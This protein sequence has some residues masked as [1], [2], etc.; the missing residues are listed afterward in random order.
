MKCNN[1]DCNFEQDGNCIEGIDGSSCSNLYD[2][3]DIELVS[4]DED[5][6]VIVQSKTA[7]DSSKTK[8]CGQLPLSIDETQVRLKAREGKIIAFVGSIGVGKT[9]LISSMYD[10]FHKH[11]DLPMKFGCSDT[12]F[13][14]ESLCHHAR[15]TSRA[16]Q[17]HTPRTSVSE[18]VAFYHLAVKSLIGKRIDLFLADRAGESYTEIP[19]NLEFASS[20]VE[21]Q[22][23]DL[24]L[25][26]VDASCLGNLR[27][28]HVTRRATI[29]LIKSF[30]ESDILLPSK[31]CCL[32]LTKYDLVLGEDA[33]KIAESESEKI[34]SE[35]KRITTIDL[36]VMSISAR[37]TSPEKMQLC[38][39]SALMN[40]I[41]ASKI[42][43]NADEFE[44]YRTGRSFHNLE[45]ID[46]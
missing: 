30:Y 12:L 29:N 27:T 37:P 31:K 7:V 11:H 25:F 20:C 2:F 14:F 33:E 19:N 9:T 8:I 46:E 4:P 21:I 44:K 13:A 35:V 32:L 28:R 10:V 41:H 26:L 23:A 3:S 34:K 40:L 5:E 16:T 18:G 42:P 38:S 43:N 22:R 45:L 36:D 17:V 1:P 6:D 24:V 15:I 39:F